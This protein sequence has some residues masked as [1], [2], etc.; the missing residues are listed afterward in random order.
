ML[1]LL[2]FV[3]VAASLTGVGHAIAACLREWFRGRAE[4]IRA[5]R[6]DL[7]SPVVVQLTDAPMDQRK[8]FH[9]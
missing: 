8:H 3:I 7:P 5:Q 4:L 1:Y 2:I 6:G 9:G